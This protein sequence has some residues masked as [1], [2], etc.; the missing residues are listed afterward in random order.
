INNEGVCGYCFATSNTVYG[1][2]S[3][4]IHGTLVSTKLND[5][6]QT[7]PYVKVDQTQLAKSHER[8]NIINVY[9]KI[10]NSKGGEVILYITRSD[11]II[12]QNQVHIT[13]DG[14]FYSPLIFDRYSLIGI[15]EIYAVFKILNL[16]S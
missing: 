2:I 5:V 6:Q 7:P 1:L 11:G 12:E 4:Q 10:G 9:G 8:P 14:T 3:D 16:G 13:S 15:Y